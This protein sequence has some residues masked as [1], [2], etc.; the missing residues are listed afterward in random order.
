[1]ELFAQKPMSYL[2]IHAPVDAR[3]DIFDL[4]FRE[5]DDAIYLAERLDSL[6]TAALTVFSTF[7]YHRHVRG[8]ITVGRQPF[9]L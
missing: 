3:V 8:V 7:L 2:D 9:D 6:A 4:E 1:M 5:R